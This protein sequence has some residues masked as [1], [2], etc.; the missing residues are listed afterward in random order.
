MLS[1]IEGLNSPQHEAVTAGFGHILVLAGAGSGKTRVLVNRCAWLV[2]QQGLSINQIL[3]VT[4]TNKAAGEIKHRLQTLLEIPMAQAWV[5]TFHGLCY[6][7]LRR[8]AEEAGLPMHF[9]ILDSDDQSRLIKLLI[10]DKKLDEA[11]WPVKAVQSFIN[12]KK[13]EGIR[14]KQVVPLPYG[15]SRI[16]A[17]LYEAYEQ[18][19]KQAGFVDFSEL[20]LKCCELFRDKPE[21]LQ[22]YHQQFKAILVDE[23]QDTNT[24]QYPGFLVSRADTQVMVVGMINPFMDGVGPRLKISI[25]SNKIFPALNSFDWNK[26]TVQRPPF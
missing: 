6:R 23:F 16:Y 11:Q 3:A 4:F 8:H 25:N 13:E 2:N 12:G 20:L 24:I 14:A 26:I 22:T 7:M 17:S 15:P 18:R 10:Q 19:C 21:L 9:Q 1:V 5:G